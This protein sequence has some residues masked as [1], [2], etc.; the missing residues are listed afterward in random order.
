MNFPH[1][2]LTEK[3]AIAGQISP[4]QLPEIGAAGFKSI[5]CNRPD[6]EGGPSQPSAD[7]IKAACQPLDIAFAYLPVSPF[8]GTP[9]QAIQLG[10]LL[11]TL[12][13]PVLVYCASGGRCMGLVG[14]ASQ[15]GQ[16]IPA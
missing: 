3:L 13:T 11:E 14:L 8:G 9:A 2:W 10:T 7:E 1:R 4:D 5:I 16:K 15:L 6:G 12:P